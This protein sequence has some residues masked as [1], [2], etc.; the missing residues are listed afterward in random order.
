MFS[1]H[2]KIELT[3]D[4]MRANERNR[5][6]SE[7]QCWR[8]NKMLVKRIAFG[9]GVQAC[10]N[11]S[12]RDKTGGVGATPVGDCELRTRQWMV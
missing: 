3:L 11:A 8:S 2:T 9:G 5:K 12:P 7:V 6:R 1:Y 10:G 4:K